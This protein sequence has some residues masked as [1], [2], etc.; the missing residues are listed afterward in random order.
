MVGIS[1]HADERLA[2][3]A[4]RSTLGSW[5]RTA[6]VF[7]RRRPL[8]ALGALIVLLLILVAAFAPLIAPYDPLDTNFIAILR[9]PSPE[10]WLGTDAFGRDLL[11]RLIYGAR[12]ALLI[13][14]TSSIVGATLGM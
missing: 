1:G 7:A 9:P 5:A 13:G 4:A 8:G 10:N 12:T 3:P 14:F 11:S 6:V 2:A